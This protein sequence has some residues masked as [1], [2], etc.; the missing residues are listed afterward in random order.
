ME[1]S[2]CRVGQGATPQPLGRLYDP[3]TRKLCPREQFVPVPFY[4]GELLES[5][6]KSNQSRGSS[7]LRPASCPSTIS[8]RNLQRL[9]S[10][11][12]QC[13]RRDLRHTGSRQPAANDRPVTAIDDRCQRTP[14]VSTTKDVRRIDGP[15]SVR[16]LDPRDP[17]PD[18]RAL[19]TGTLPDLPLFPFRMR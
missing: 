10:A 6:A 4:A 8:L 7:P 16:L 12:L 15:P 3:R 1:R 14:A 13:R 17:A 11:V 19:A 18:P 2:S 9:S 5:L